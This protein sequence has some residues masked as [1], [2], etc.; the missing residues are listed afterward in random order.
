MDF[1]NIREKS[2]KIGKDRKVSK[3]ADAFRKTS[4]AIQKAPDVC[5]IIF[6]IY[7]LTME[8]AYSYA[9]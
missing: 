8:I 3:T 5:F 6:N 9:H 7:R 1:G 4:S 2:V